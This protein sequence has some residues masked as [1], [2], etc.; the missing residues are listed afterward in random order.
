MQAE[1]HLL[2]VELLIEQYKRDPALRGF[3]AAQLYE[4]QEIEDA[5]QDVAQSRDLDLATGAALDLFGV[6][7]GQP[8]NGLS[9][10]LYRIFLKARV[11]VNVGN[12]RGEEILD[13]LKQ[14]IPAGGTFSF[15]EMYP[16]GFFVRLYGVDPLLASA[17]GGLVCKV[18][19]AGIGCTVSLTPDPPA[20]FFYGVS[21][22]GFGSSNSAITGGPWTGLA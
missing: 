8:R 10:D 16:A 6:F 5:A 13:L 1:N 17:I 4:S 12:G 3:I 19:G 14:T 7:I 20:G 15:Y 21:S 22:L 2:M 11:L 18:K 9:D